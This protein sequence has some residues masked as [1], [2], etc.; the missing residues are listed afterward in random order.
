MA[1]DRA[2]VRN[3]ADPRQVK[4]AKKREKLRRDGELADMRAVLELPEGRRML[5]RLM[6]HCKTFESVFDELATTM[7]FKAGRQDVG[8]FV[9]VE[10]LAADQTKFALMQAESLARE[11]SDFTVAEA[12]QQTAEGRA[13][14]MDDRDEDETDAQ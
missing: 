10:I 4:D 12:V 6:G 9:M 8:H 14:T 7:A 2:L 5:W 11:N 1:E 3:A 13:I